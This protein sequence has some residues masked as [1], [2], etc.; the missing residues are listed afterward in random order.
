MLLQN[1]PR[2]ITFGWQQAQLLKACTSAPGIR[3]TNVPLKNL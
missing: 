1:T 3:C 2:V